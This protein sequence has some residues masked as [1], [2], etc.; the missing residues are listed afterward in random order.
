MKARMILGNGLNKEFAEYQKNI[1]ETEKTL[2]A[3]VFWKQ[4]ELTGEWLTPE[5]I[6]SAASELLQGLI[7]ANLIQ[8]G[9]IVEGVLECINDCINN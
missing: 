7:D 3:Y 6:K 9:K 1:F 5:Q 8:N 4:I 2:Q